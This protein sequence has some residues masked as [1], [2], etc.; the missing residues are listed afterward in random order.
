MR[1]RLKL[2]NGLMCTAFLVVISVQVPALAKSAAAT[3]DKSST[4]RYMVILADMP[5]ATY[6]GRVMSTPEMDDSKTQLSP[7]ANNYTG[8]KKLDVRAPASVQYLHFLDDRFKAF[9]GEALL[10]LG[11]EIN[12]VYR[13]RNVLNGLAVDLTASEARILL[14]LPM[15]TA[16]EQ[17]KLHHIRTDAGPSWIGADKIHNGST[18]H[19]ATGGEGV[20]VGMIDT[21]INWD[22]PSFAD[23]GQSGTG[24]NHVNPNGTQ[25]GLCSDPEV[26]CNDKLVGVFDYIEDNPDTDFEEQNT[27]GKDIDGHGSH[28]SSTAAGNPLSFNYKGLPTN[29]SGVAPNANIISYRVCFEGDPEDPEDDGGCSPTAAVKA[30]DQAIVDDVDIINYSIGGNSYNPWLQSQST[31]A[32]LNARAAGMFV[33]ASAGN[34]GPNGGTIRSPANAPWVTSVGNASHDRVYGVAL[35]NL[36]GG[37]TAVPDDQIG[38]SLVGGLGVRKIVHAKDFGNAICG[39]GTAEL[40]PDC[41]GNTGASNPFPANTFNGEIVVCDRGP[42]DE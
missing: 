39:T 25:L 7:T 29:I 13:Y 4:H 21:G 41:S 27:K 26:M 30:L 3:V 18:G 32:F 34:D 36:S 40:A 10:R 35:E 9:K 16:V 14:E 20:I 23:P 11:R 17:E 19:P 28:T 6:D 42:M 2:I 1:Y 15:V 8:S 31:F 22:N 37:D 24:W 5:L 38:T 12:P 33:A